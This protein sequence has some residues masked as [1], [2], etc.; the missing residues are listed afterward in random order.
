MSIHAC[1]I[2]WR[3]RKGNESGLT[4]GGLAVRDGDVHVVLLAVL[5][6]GEA[7]EV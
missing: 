4:Q 7:L 1:V 5:V 3:G 2:L 6:D